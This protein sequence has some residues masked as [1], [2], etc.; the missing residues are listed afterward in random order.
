MTQTDYSFW[1]DFVAVAHLA[2]AGFIVVALAIILFGYL[3]KWQWVRNPWFRTIHLI[4]IG[5]VVAE[6][7]LG[8]TCPLT[9]W[10]ISLRRQ[11]GTSFDGT[12]TAQFVHGFL[13]YD[14]PWWVFTACYSAC[15][16][17]IFLTLFLVPP[18]WSWLRDASTPSPTNQV[19]AES[20]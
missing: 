5:I 8:I 2:Y 3:L 17:L 15:G 13:F 14:A 6:A 10:E 7:W 4:M 9:T 1:A 16:A 20:S 18:K 19:G 11:A 12:P